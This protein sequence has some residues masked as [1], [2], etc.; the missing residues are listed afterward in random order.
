M[1]SKRASQIFLSDV[2]EQCF[3]AALNGSF[4]KMAFIDGA[5]WATAAP[6]LCMSIN[7]ASSSEVLLWNRELVPTILGIE[8]SHGDFQGPL[9]GIVILMQRCRIQDHLLLSGSIGW[10]TNETAAEAEPMSAFASKV[11]RIL[12]SISTPAVVC[13]NPADRTALGDP[14]SGFLVGNDAVRWCAADSDRRL[15]YRSTNN[16]LLPIDLVA[17]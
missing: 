13:V 1:Q 12:R 9:S 11:W 14:V 15:K 5:R 17:K 7:E 2:D 8:Q 3:S 6:P 4:S 16:Y 10:G